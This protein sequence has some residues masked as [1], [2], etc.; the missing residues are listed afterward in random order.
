MS[1][2]ARIQKTAGGNTRRFLLMH[3]TE[4]SPAHHCVR[5]CCRP[6]TAHGAQLKTFFARSI[7]IKR[8]SLFVRSAHH[9]HLVPFESMWHGQVSQILWRA[10]VDLAA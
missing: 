8:H 9:G 3:P 7:A 1:G 2:T 4:S 10:A 5:F 6:M